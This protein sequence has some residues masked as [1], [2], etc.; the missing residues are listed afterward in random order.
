MPIIN[1]KNWRSMAAVFR[2][3]DSGIPSFDAVTRA[4]IADNYYKENLAKALRAAVLSEDI[5]GI[6]D[7]RLVTVSFDDGRATSDTLLVIEVTGRSARS[8]QEGSRSTCLVAQ[9]VRKGT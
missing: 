7:P 3:V 9:G 5:P 1:V 6:D 8:N 4:I 2:S